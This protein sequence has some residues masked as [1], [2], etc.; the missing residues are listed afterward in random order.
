MS[1]HTHSADVAYVRDKMLD[2]QP[3]PALSK[4]IVAWLRESLFSS[5]PYTILTLFCIYVLYVVIPP[6]VSFMLTNAVWTGADRSVARPRR[7]AAF[8]R[9]AGSAPAG[10][11]SAHT[12]P[13]RLRTLSRCRAM[14]RK[15][16]R[17]SVF[18]RLDPAPD[19]VGSIQA[20]KHPFRICDLPARRADPADRRPFRYRRP[21]SAARHYRGYR[22]WRRIRICLFLGIGSS[23]ES[24]GCCGDFRGIVH[25]PVH[26]RFR[27]RPEPMSRRKCGAACW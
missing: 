12:Q 3:A 23:T 17:H 4:G 10:P 27:F 6:I 15:H 22:S 2:E 5:I 9:M 20:R 16:R 19:A 25:S 1:N 24:Q 18:W 7:R 26:P 14:A 8:S 21:L 11:M 13:V